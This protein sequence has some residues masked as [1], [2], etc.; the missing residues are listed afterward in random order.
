VPDRVRRVWRTV[1]PAVARERVARRLAAGEPSRA[2]HADVAL[3]EGDARNESFASF[4]GIS[5]P[6]PLIRVNTTDGYAPDLTEILK[7]INRP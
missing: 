5:I 3:L 2:A 4:D 1:D 6:A 7:F